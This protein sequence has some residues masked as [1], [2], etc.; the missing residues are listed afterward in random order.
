M[1][2]YFHL[3]WIIPLSA[4]AGFGLHALCVAG[5]EEWKEGDMNAFGGGNQKIYRKRF[6]KR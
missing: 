3:L 6:G 5:K 4:C 2:N 1:M